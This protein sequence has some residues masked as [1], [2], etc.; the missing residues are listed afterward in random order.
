MSKVDRLRL[1]GTFE[2]RDDA[3]LALEHT[4]DMALVRRGIP[5]LLVIRCP[6]GCGDNL[7]VNLDPR[8]GSAW[9][10][11]VRND[12]VTLF[13]SYWRDS[14]CGSHFILWSNRV[15]WCTWE[16]DEDFWADTSLIQDRVL[17]GL[18]SQFMPYQDLAETIGEIPWEVLQACHDL[19]RKGLAEANFGR[20][21]GE[22][23]RVQAAVPASSRL[24]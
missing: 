10:S 2:N 5:R 14:A 24:S 4:G 16:H 3:A 1:V 22:F 17:A 7:I 8:A 23:R 21:R 18:T 11:Y 9:R 19:S 6:C 15:H 20:R 12:H 13:P